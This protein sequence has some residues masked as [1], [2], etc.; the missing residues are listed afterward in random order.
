[1]LREKIRARKRAAY[2]ADP[3]ADRDA[4]RRRRYGITRERFDALFAIQKGL[5]AICSVESA[6]CVDH[7][8][9]T[10]NIR[11]LLCMHCN[12][13]L[14]LFQ[15]DVRILLHAANYLRKAE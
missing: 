2:A 4:R 1:V 14:G 13:G 5:C 11:G 9:S 12:A 8:H 7:D 3:I 15:D 10:G 6:G